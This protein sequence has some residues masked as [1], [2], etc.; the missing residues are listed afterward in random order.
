MS[1]EPKAEIRPTFKDIF[2][3]FVDGIQI[4]TIHFGTETERTNAVIHISIQP[5]FW[6]PAAKYLLKEVT[7]RGYDVYLR[8]EQGPV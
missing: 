6:R 7:V 5:R 8:L 4:G 2:G 1:S 3:I